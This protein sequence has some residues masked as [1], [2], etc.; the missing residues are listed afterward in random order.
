MAYSSIPLAC[1]CI[2]CQTALL[3]RSMLSRFMHAFPVECFCFA[4][5]AHSMSN[6]CKDY[7]GMPMTASRLATYTAQC[8][9]AQHTAAQ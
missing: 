8:K 1:W 6:R 5:P 7:K 2:R 3:L 4:L 9:A